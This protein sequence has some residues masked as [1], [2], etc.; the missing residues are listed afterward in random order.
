MSA[1]FMPLAALV[2]DPLPVIRGVARSMNSMNLKNSKKFLLDA[3]D[4]LLG[5]GLGVAWDGLVK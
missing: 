2:V 1:V 4:G 3:L 5:V